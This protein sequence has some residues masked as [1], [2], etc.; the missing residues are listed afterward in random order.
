MPGALIIGGGNDDGSAG[1]IDLA[2]NQELLLRPG[3]QGGFHIFLNVRMSESD[4][5]STSYVYLDRTAKR[6]RDGELLFQSRE[7]V[8]FTESAEPGYFE[9]EYPIRIILCPTQ[10]DRA[11]IAE[12]LLVGVEADGTEA[13]GVIRVRPRCPDDDLAAFCAHI[14]SG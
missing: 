5:T 3:I 10:R 1:F 8:S 13:A 11:V 4:M 14:C 12:T 7:R 2:E 6:E 9:T